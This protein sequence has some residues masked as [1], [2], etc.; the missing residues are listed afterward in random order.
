M[1]VGDIVVGGF[2]VMTDTVTLVT[3]ADIPAGTVI[4]ITDRGWDNSTGAFTT[5]TTGDGVIT[6]TVSS[7]IAAGTVLELFVGGSDQTTTLQNLTANTNLSADIAET[8]H[9]VTDPFLLNGDQI[10]I[11]EGDDSNPRFVSGFNASTPASQ[12]ATMDPHQWH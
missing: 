12:P 5:G 3:T 6:W 8:G 10:F 9:T 2:N 4:K 1:N 11:Y 7:E